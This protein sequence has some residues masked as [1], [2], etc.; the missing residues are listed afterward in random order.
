[1]PQPPSVDV[2]ILAALPMEYSAVLEVSEGILEGGWVP[3]P[4]PG[5]Q[6]G[7]GGMEASRATFAASTGILH[8]LALPLAS[9]GQREAGVQASALIERHNPRVVCMPGIC[10]GYESKI[11]LGDVILADRVFSVGEGKLKG[12]PTGTGSTVHLDDQHHYPVLPPWDQRLGPFALEWS[13]EEHPW[14]DSRPLAQDLQEAWFL[15]RLY[16]EPTLEPRRHGDAADK[17][18]DGTMVY[19]SLLRKGLIERHGVVATLTETGNN[20]LEE[21]L[22][23]FAGLPVPK[24]FQ[25]IK[26]PIATGH[27][28]VE[29]ADAFGVIHTTMRKALGLEMELVAIAHAARA[30]AIPFLAAKGV[31]DFADPGRDQDERFQTFAARAS[32][33]CL[34]AFLRRHLPGSGPRTASVPAPEAVTDEPAIPGLQGDLAQ[35]LSGQLMEP[36]RAQLSRGFH[37][38]LRTFQTGR[39]TPEHLAAV[40]FS[41]E[42]QALGITL[43]EE[44][45]NPALDELRRTEPQAVG[46]ACQ[47]GII[48]GLALLDGQKLADL[49]PTLNACGLGLGGACHPVTMTFGLHGLLDLTH[50]EL[51][52]RGGSGAQVALST[53]NAIDPP[54]A[55]GCF[56][57]GSELGSVVETLLDLI[58]MRYLAMPKDKSLE[59][60]ERPTR[61]EA[62]AWAPVSN[63]FRAIKSASRHQFLYLTP[64]D[65]SLRA[66]Q[67]EVMTVLGDLVPGIR[68][69]VAEPAATSLWVGCT[70]DDFLRFM[71]GLAAH[72]VPGLPQVGPES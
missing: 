38:K 14:L 22:A 2:L 6:A 8:I 33:E 16:L 55:D 34:L 54:G 42:A 67:Q 7:L 45:F 10:A 53:R 46:R 64:V 48:L 17:C 28:V 40:C 62:Q 36:F 56:V 12:K 66:L 29:V 37:R 24:P 21:L 9:I 44:I 59:L 47:A 3:S 50:L 32:S 63:F 19:D 69:K 20:H 71:E 51:C 1:M 65:P 41:P 30:H 5:G 26:A 13:R 15:Y 70:E 31:S 60:R 57:T 23:R 11:N 58:W 52:P 72:G 68:I 25:A 39:A 18:P 4:E 49:M 61:Q 43:L 35:S 27:V